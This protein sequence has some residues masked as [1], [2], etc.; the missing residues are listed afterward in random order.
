MKI[1]LAVISFIIL[2]ILL[3]WVIMVWFRWSYVEPVI[4]QPFDIISVVVHIRFKTILVLFFICYIYTALA[5]ICFNLLL[6][7]NKKYT[8]I[9]LYFA[10]LS[11]LFSGL[12]GSLY[13]LYEATR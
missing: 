5:S 2:T 8:R 11:I 9:L 4:N 6:N 12:F 13:G 3:S 1:K 10:F 7:L